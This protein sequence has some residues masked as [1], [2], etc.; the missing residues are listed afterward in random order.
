MLLGI[1]PLR[2]STVSYLHTEREEIF[3]NPD[4][5]RMS[6]VWPQEKRQLLIDS[7]VNEFDIPKL[8]FHELDPPRL[9]D[10]S[11]LRY[12][13]V[14]GK[15]RLQAIWG[16]M[17]GQFPL[18]SDFEYLPD[19]TVR[20]AGMSYAELAK[21]YPR[22]SR[23]FD[24][25]PLPVVVIQTDDVELI[26]DMFSR[27]NEA[28][29]LNAPEKRNAL[30]GPLPPTIRQ[31]AQNTFFTRNLPFSNSRYRHYDLAAKF[32]YI[33]HHKEF[34]DTKKVYLDQFVKDFKNEGKK[35]DAKELMAHV[36]SVLAQMSPFFTD[37]DPLLRSVGMSV[38][39]YLLFREV[40]EGSLEKMPGRFQLMEFEHTRAANRELA[41]RDMAAANYDLLEFDRLSQSMNDELAMK[42]RFRV[43]REHLYGLQE[44][45][46]SSGKS[47]DE[48]L[49][50]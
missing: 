7:I 22:V 26:E 4:Y 41:E 2:N 37:G 49:S 16:F 32:L 36:H 11:V 48:W 6:D 23:R 39:Y 47:V 14:D 45:R 43:L 38:L 27:L 50:V 5:Q 18:S 42:Y 10:G 46:D 13:I 1:A 44:G 29:P 17:D 19:A 31:T 35:S 28:I 40:V 33:E 24:S 8:Y 20:A 34:K 12:A 15:Q 21:A 30:G 9:E 3:M 25:T